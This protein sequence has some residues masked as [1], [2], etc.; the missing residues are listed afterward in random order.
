MLF[1]LIDVFGGWIL[2][3]CVVFDLNFGVIVCGCFLLVGLRC[4]GFI[5][6]LYCL[7]WVLVWGVRCLRISRI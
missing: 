1:G 3:V 7:L 2:C 6:Q 5:V 4:L